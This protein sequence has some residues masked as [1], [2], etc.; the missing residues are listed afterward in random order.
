[1]TYSWVEDCD[2]PIAAN[3]VVQSENA[4]PQLGVHRF[5]RCL[6]ERTSLDLKIE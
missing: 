2:H 6:L 5:V 4:P 3:D 1:M